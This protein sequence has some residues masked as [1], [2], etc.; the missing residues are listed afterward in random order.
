MSHDSIYLYP[1]ESYQSPLENYQFADF[2]DKAYDQ[3]LEDTRKNYKSKNKQVAK[4]IRCGFKEFYARVAANTSATALKFMMREKPQGEKKLEL[5]KED[6]EEYR[7][8]KLKGNNPVKWPETTKEFVK[9]INALPWHAFSS[10][11][12]TMFF[13]FVESAKNAIIQLCQKPKV[14]D[15]KLQDSY[16]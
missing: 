12:E 11:S 4:G 14:V 16:K 15:G 1:R 10:D 3:L 9:D 8:Q 6:E 2:Q 5:P 13:D 7:I